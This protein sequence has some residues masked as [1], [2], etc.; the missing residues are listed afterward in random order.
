M[1]GIS[2]ERGGWGKYK[3]KLLNCH[4]RVSNS[5]S[6]RHINLDNWSIILWNFSAFHGKLQLMRTD[7]D[8]DL[9]LVTNAMLGHHVTGHSSAP[10]YCLIVQL[11]EVTAITTPHNSYTC[12]TKHLPQLT[13]NFSPNTTS[14]TIFVGFSRPF[15]VRFMDVYRTTQSFALFLIYIV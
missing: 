2:V 7:D 4:K 3:T 6:Q 11:R 15:Q 8:Q 13:N 5:N 12:Q 10:G 1:L 14:H 9:Y